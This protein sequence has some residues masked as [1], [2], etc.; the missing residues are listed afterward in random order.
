MTIEPNRTFY[1]SSKQRALLEKNG[2]RS[3]AL[4]IAGTYARHIYNRLLN[5]I[6]KGGYN[7]A[8]VVVYELNDPRPLVSLYCFSYLRTCEQYNASVESVLVF[9]LS[10]ARKVS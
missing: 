7:S 3:G 4:A 8:M 10:R 1:L 6:P 5:D 9:E 2:G